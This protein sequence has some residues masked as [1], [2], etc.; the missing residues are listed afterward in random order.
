MGSATLLH[1]IFP[2]VISLI[3][4]SI[5]LRAVKK[6][7]QLRRRYRL[8][9]PSLTI[10]NAQLAKPTSDIASHTSALTRDDQ[11]L[12]KLGFDSLQTVTQDEFDTALTAQAAFD[13]VTDVESMQTN[14]ADEVIPPEIIILHVFAKAGQQ[15]VGY[16]LLQAIL[17]CGF[18]FGEMDIFHRHQQPNGR[19]N[20][21]FSL[22]S[23]TEPGA[24]DMNAMGGYTCIGLTLFM[25]PAHV[26]QA[27]AVFDLMLNT[28]NQL[29]DDLD[30]IVVDDARQLLQADTIAQ[31]RH[32]LQYLPN[33][34]GQTEL[35]FSLAG[36]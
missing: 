3:G 26:K 24:F 15:F 30:G 12:A 4:I 2:V 19:G 16:E 17:A 18:R 21:L 20:V 5:L 27:I 6:Q 9:Q 1:L 14:I 8:D 35:E 11:R 13:P 23:A 7:Q 10:N 25:H 33:D 28:A 29:A 36:S 34:I 32:S 31:I 22:A